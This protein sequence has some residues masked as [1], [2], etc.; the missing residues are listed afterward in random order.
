ML[1]LVTGCTGVQEPPRGTDTPAPSVSRTEPSEPTA[2]EEPTEPPG[3][4]ER[5]G[6][7]T[8]WGPSEAELDDAVRWARQLSLPE[9]AGQ[10]I[11][12]SWSGTRAPVGCC[13]CR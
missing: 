2:T 11:V 6:L 4:A 12:A 5:L 9:L 7:A 13:A 3:P 8:G 10:L 1:I